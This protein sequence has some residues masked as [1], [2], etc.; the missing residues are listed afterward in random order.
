MVKKS[1]V[2]LTILFL[3]AGLA[4]ADATGDYNFI[5]AQTLQK[6]IEK[7]ASPIIIDIC[8]VEQYA[9]GHI[10]GSIETNAYP[11]KT[12]AQ[13]ARLAEYLPKIK[14]SPGQVVIVCPR[15]AGGAKRTYE[16]YKSNGVQSS[17]LLIL[18]N[19]MNGWPFKTVKK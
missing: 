4:W 17:R 9:Q 8:P 2:C 6:Q 7:K 15:G 1:L 19:G 12:E 3:A 5:S 11:V 18:E 16:Y 10:I 14:E 13:K